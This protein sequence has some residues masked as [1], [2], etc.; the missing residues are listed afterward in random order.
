MGKKR[1]GRGEREGEGIR[2]GESDGEGRKKKSSEQSFC[3]FTI[4]K[5]C[6]LLLLPR[7]V[8]LICLRKV[9]VC[10]LQIIKF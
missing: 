4:C 2:R 6:S 3:E 7:E 9:D 10:N 1:E 5:N 8:P